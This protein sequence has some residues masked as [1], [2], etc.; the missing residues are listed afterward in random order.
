MKAKQAI[1][2][3]DDE[4]RVRVLIHSFLSEDYDV[5][6]AADGLEAMACYEL[7]AERIA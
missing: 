1:L 6:L 5:L 3:V 4:E 2:V 7:H